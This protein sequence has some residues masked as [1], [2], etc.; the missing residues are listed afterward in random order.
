MVHV[1][2]YLKSTNPTYRKHPTTYLN[3]EHW[4]DDIPQQSNG[5]PSAPDL[6][7]IATKGKDLELYMKAAKI[8]RE[9]GWENIQ[10]PGSTKRVW[11]EIKQ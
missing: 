3:G 1:P 11:R 10:P 2:L 6:T 9:N 5:I 7:W 8:W 4:N